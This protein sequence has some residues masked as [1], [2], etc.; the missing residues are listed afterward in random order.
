MTEIEDDLQHRPLYTQ[1]CWFIRLRWFAAIAILS[2]GIINVSWLSWYQFNLQIFFTGVFILAY[3]LILRVL[4]ARHV[5]TPTNRLSLISS[6]WIQIILDLGCL[7]MLTCWTGVW[8]SPLL[9]F[10]VFHM[11]FASLLLPQI[12]AWGA[13]AV[14]MSMLFGTFWATGNWPLIYQH[15][16]IAIGWVATLIIT[17]YI[18]NQITMSLRRQRRRLVRK[19][20]RIRQMTMRLK[21][22]QLAMIQ[23][24]K[25]VAMGQMAAGIAHEIANPLAS[26]DSVLQL[27][28]RHPEV[29]RPGAVKTLSEQVGRVNQIIRQM[30]EFAHPNDSDGQVL[31]MN[32]IVEGALHMVRFDR[33]IKRVKVICD[34]NNPSSGSFCA[35]PQALQ[36]V[37][38]NLIMNALAALEDK[39]EPILRLSTACIDKFCHITVG[40]TG[41]G[42]EAQHLDRIFEPFFT[43]KP[44]GKGTGLGLSISYNLIQKLGGSIEV[45]SVV[46]KG[47]TFYIKLPANKVSGLEPC[48]DK[49]SETE[50]SEIIAK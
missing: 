44:L 45:E 2:G 26:M 25:M 42:I 41:S 32:E 31:P 47:T 7:S 35:F 40:D 6:A 16:S 11:V 39:D 48:C 29:P 12:M 46:G 27:M 38:V 50:S 33:R 49:Y 15:Y 4:I 13:A 14:A 24:E 3:N 19:N 5:V 10:F 23:Q 30:T 34:L 18:A 17:V 43:T 28:K 20:R 8:F 22:Q 21:K 1:V 36:Q 9:G 37:L